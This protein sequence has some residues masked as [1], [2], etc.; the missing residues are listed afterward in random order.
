MFGVIDYL[1]FSVACAGLAWLWIAAE[2]P[3]SPTPA[4]IR[5]SWRIGR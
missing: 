4:D 1:I 3:P 2:G 5:R